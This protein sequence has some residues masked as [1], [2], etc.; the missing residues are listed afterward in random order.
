MIISH[1]MVQLN[2]AIVTHFGAVSQSN[3]S[4]LGAM[5]SL[6]AADPPIER[7]AS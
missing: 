4:R 5:G 6:C 7:V 1:Y 2:S 3:M